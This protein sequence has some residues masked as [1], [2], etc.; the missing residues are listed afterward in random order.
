M[1]NFDDAPTDGQTYEVDGRTW[2]WVAAKAVWNLVPVIEGVEDV[3]AD[4]VALVTDNSTCCGRLTLT[5]GVPVTTADVLAATVVYWTPYKGNRITLYTGGVWRVY[6]FS[7][8]SVAV[9]ATTL[10]DYDMFAYDS[11]GTVAIEA[12]AWSSG[13][14][15]TEIELFDGVYMKAGDHTRRYLGSFGTTG[16]S[17]KTESSVSKRLVYN[18]EQP[19]PLPVRTDE[20]TSSWAYSTATFRQARASAANQVDFLIGVSTHPVRLHAVSYSW[21]STATHRTMTTGIGV[22]STSV[23]S[24]HILLPVH[25]N[26]G[27]INGSQAFYDGPLPAGRHYAAWLERGAGADTQNWLG[28]SVTLQSG[29]SG[30]VF[31]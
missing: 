5:S 16:V 31:A 12:A 10:T 30:S 11:T 3:I 21:S 28:R 4:A 8:M 14:S 15:H 13:A 20:S 1:I 24:A 6:T 25:S 7:E 22:D 2:V 18:H 29:I 9:P 23:N 27:Y 17:G 19:V 26:A